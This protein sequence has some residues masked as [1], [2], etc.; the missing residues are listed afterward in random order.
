VPVA[1]HLGWRPGLAAAC[2]LMIGGAGQLTGIV[3]MRQWSTV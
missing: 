3:T 2:L 1:D